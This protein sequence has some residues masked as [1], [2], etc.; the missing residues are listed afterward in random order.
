M[1]HILYI[2]TCLRKSTGLTSIVVESGLP[3]YIPLQGRLRVWILAASHEWFSWVLIVTFHFSPRVLLILGLVDLFRNL[4]LIGSG[5]IFFLLFINFCI[6]EC[7]QSPLVDIEI[8]FFFVHISIGI[9]GQRIRFM[10][11]LF[12]HPFDVIPSSTIVFAQRMKRL[13]DV[14]GIAVAFIEL[15][16]VILDRWRGL[17]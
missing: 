3:I 11:R 10:Y 16:L 6:F 1:L 4:A 14:Q 5:A 2:Q 13:L 12:G 15:F 17:D 8:L 7:V 9:Q